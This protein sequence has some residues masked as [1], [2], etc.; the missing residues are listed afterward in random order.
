[1]TWSLAI[2]N[3]DISYGQNGLNT[4]TG[5]DKL[6][7]DLSCAI[8]EPLGTDYSDPNFGSV[9]QGGVDADGIVYPGYIGAPNNPAMQSLIASEIQRICQNYQIE[10]IQRN[11]NDLSQY[12][13]ST[14]S[15]GEA[16]LNVTSVQ[17]QQVNTM[18]YVIAELTTG[19][20][21]ITLAQGVSAT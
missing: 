5:S 18:A 11:Q 12:G 13:V 10:Q 17:V 4:V 19:G 16:L 15:A 20:G 2:K 8:L 7:Q 3:G 14:L 6:V 1:M 21:S 9:I